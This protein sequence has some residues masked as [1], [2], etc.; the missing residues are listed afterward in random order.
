MNAIDLKGRH[1]IVTGAA[2]GIGL[3]ITTRLLASGASV[4]L[5][6]RDQK[7]LSEAR[8]SLHAEDRIG[9][10]VLDVTDSRELEAAA[11]RAVR[12]RAH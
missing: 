1:A 2:Q 5:W 4:S 3:A 8:T 10:E 11:N 7:L 6:D 12:C 9:I